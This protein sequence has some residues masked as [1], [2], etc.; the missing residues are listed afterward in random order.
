MINKCKDCNKEITEEA[1]RCKPYWY[2]YFTYLI[3]AIQE[4]LRHG[5]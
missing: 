5:K 2:A 3:R 1:T 4:R